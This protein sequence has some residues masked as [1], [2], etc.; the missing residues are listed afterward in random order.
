[1]Q[2]HNVL[3]KIQSPIGIGVKTPEYVPS[4]RCG[5]CAWEETGVD[6]FKLLLGDLP[7]G[8]LFQEGLVPGAELGLAVFGVGFQ[9]FQ[10]LL[11]QSAALRIPHPVQKA[12]KLSL[13]RSFSSVFEG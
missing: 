4:I 1:M 2:R 9:F 13:L 10:D 11:G 3:L 5:V 7:T 6:A 8:T 12:R